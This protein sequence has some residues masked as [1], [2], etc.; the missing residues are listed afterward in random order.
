[1]NGEEAGYRKLQVEVMGEWAMKKVMEEGILLDWMEKKS[2]GL[3]GWNVRDEAMLEL[4]LLKFGAE[5]DRVAW[6]DKLVRWVRE[7]DEFFMC[8]QRL[9]DFLLGVE[10]EFSQAQSARMGQLLS[11]AGLD[12]V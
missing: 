11:A 6:E 10:G 12:P 4:G 5:G 2:V 8:N 1:M 9:A 7:E 3:L